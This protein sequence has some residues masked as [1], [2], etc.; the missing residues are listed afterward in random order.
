MRKALANLS[1]GLHGDQAQ[2]MKTAVTTVRAVQSEC[3][4][5]GWSRRSFTGVLPAAPVA[6]SSRRLGPEPHGFPAPRGQQQGPAPGG[7][8]MTGPLDLQPLRAIQAPSMLRCSN[9]AQPRLKSS[10]AEI[11]D[12]QRLHGR[13]HPFCPSRKEGTEQRKGRDRRG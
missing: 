7:L 6:R 11:E 4:F 1:Q 13:E 5:K 2:Q 10:P 9:T 8:T 12:D 3:D